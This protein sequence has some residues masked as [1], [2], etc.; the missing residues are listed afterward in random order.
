MILLIELIFALI[1]I[2][3]IGY[4]IVFVLVLKF[5]HP[6]VIMK[7]YHFVPMVSI[8]IPTMNEEHF[9]EKRLGNLFEMSYPKEKLEVIFVDNSNDN[10]AKII[11]DY[12]RK[13]PF[14][15]LLKQEKNGFNNALNQ[16]Y[17]AASGDIVI[18]SDCTALPYSNALSEIVANFA[19]ALV[20]AV[21]GVHVF[22]HANEIVEKEFKGIMY[23]VQLME[24]YLHSSLI[25]HGSFGA[26]RKK[27]IPVLEQ[28]ITADDSEVVINVVRNGYRAIVDT[29]VKSSEAPPVSSKEWRSQKSRRAGGVIKVMLRNLDMTFNRKYG[30]F[31]LVTIPVELFLLVISP[32]V[33][34]SLMIFWAI[35]LV[36]SPSVYLIFLTIVIVAGGGCLIGIS[37]KFRA[38]VDTYLSCFFGLFQSFSKKKTW[39]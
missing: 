35:L 21:T 9:I 8:V 3:L 25:S 6:T 18:K 16:G 10:T 31:G 34:F 14:L 11:Y 1:S 33:L 37:A 4:A 39:K 5:A 36:V 24:S 23:K 27:L 29:N 17:S 13:Y 15:K 38:I 19:D 28:E 12:S 20:G 22:N 26:Y 30:N 7:D 32:M 2:L